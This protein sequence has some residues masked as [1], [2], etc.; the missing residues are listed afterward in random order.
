MGHRTLDLPVETLEHILWLIPDSDDAKES[1]NRKHRP[2]FLACALVC[3]TWM[4]LARSRLL[5]LYF[6]EGRVQIT[7][8]GK[9]RD[10]VTIFK[11]PL[12]TLDP[13]FIKTLCLAPY[14]NPLYDYGGSHFLIRLDA[15]LFPS[16]QSLVFHRSL[17][18]FETR[19]G[20][21]SVLSRIKFLSICPPSGTPFECVIHI[22]Q[23]CPFVEEINLTYDSEQDSSDRDLYEELPP[24]KSL[25]KLVVDV[26]T[27]RETTEWLTRCQPAPTTIVSLEI[28]NFTWDEDVESLHLQTLLDH[29]GPNLEELTLDLPHEFGLGIPPRM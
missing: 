25:R 13:A 7:K 17:L 23:L 16:L 29:L 3:K 2:T 28:S 6:R 14:T 26:P 24:P 20:S 21:R 18:S 8:P 12:C 15:S 5:S 4:F 11:S 1:W 10:L 22:I 27:L 9:V 19:C